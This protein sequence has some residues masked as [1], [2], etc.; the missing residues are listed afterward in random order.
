MKGLRSFIRDSSIPFSLFPVI[1]A[2]GILLTV[3][4]AVKR[5]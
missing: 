2:T 3:L 4:D 5:K 1:T